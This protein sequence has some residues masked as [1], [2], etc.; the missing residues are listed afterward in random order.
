MF[1]GIYTSF[2]HFLCSANCIVSVM[3]MFFS[4]DIGATCFIALTKVFADKSN[5]ICI[6]LVIYIV[7]YVV[8]VQFYAVIIV[9]KVFNGRW[10]HIMSIIVIM[11]I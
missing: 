11:V 1:Q 6:L 8:F 9:M 3:V 2:N 5:V 10:K 7:S 4:F